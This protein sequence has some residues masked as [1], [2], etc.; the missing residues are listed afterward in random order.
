MA[1]FVVENSNDS[2]SDI[3]GSLT[4]RQALLHADAT[5]ETDT[6][7]FS[8]SFLASDDATVRL[9]SQVVLTTNVV[10]D[11]DLDDDGVADI[12]LLGTSN[13]QRLFT[14]SSGTTT[15]DTVNLERGNADLGGAIL[16]E[17]GA[18]LNLN[19]STVSQGRADKGGA[20]Y[21][22]GKLFVDESTF[23]SN[24]ATDSGGAIHNALFGEVTLTG[25]TIRTNF[26][27]DDD[28]GGG[29][30]IFNAGGATLN[31]YSSTLHNNTG[32][33]GG[34]LTN[35]GNATLTNA[36]FSSNSAELGGGILNRGSLSL[37]N[38]TISGNSAQGQG[39]GGIRN[40]LSLSLVN[41]IVI[42][43][44]VTD[45]VTSASGS[46]T[47]NSEL[48]SSTTADSIFAA[49]DSNGGG[50]L[51]DNGGPV[52][53]IALKF[54]ASNR[55]L[56]Q[57]DDDAAPTFDAA[58][59][60]RFD[61]GGVGIDNTR[62]DLGALELVGGQQLE[63]T[64]LDDVVDAFDGLVSLREALTTAKSIAGTD[65]ITFN[66]PG[67]L[68]LTSSLQIDD[69]V[70]ISGSVFEADRAITIT[71][72]PGTRVLTIDGGNV[73]LD[74]LTIEN[75]TN[76]RTGGISI[77][78]S[79]TVDINNSYFVG[80]RATEGGGAIQNLGILNVTNSTFAD[81]TGGRA[82]AI[83]NNGTLTVT[84]S[85]LNG[86]DAT[87]D[88]G[89]ILNYKT[90]EVANS[91]FEFNTTVGSGGAISNIGI[92]DVI[93]S[94]FR[95]NVAN[96]GGG[97]ANFASGST[98]TLRNS[99]FTENVANT[100]GGG[101]S[102]RFGASSNIITATFV[103]NTATTFGGGIYSGGGN[104][105]DPNFADSDDPGTSI[106]NVTHSTFLRNAAASSGG[107]IYNK[108][109]AFNL[110]N[111]IVLGNT[112]G[113]NVV[114][115]VALAQAL[116]GLGGQ[117]ASDVFATLDGVVGVLAD[118]GGAVQT[119]TL[120][121]DPLNPA[122]D[123]GN[124][125]AIGFPA[126]DARGQSRVDLG[127]V[128]NNGINI[129]DLGALELANGK[130]A[131]TSGAAVTVAEGTLQVIDMSAV[132]DFS[133]ELSG[134]AYALVDVA[135]AA[136]FSL[137][138][139]TGVLS[140]KSAPDFERPVDVAANNTYVVVVAV[141]DGTASSSQVLTITVTNINDAA[142]VF[143]SAASASIAEGT[144]FVLDAQATDDFA[145]EGDGLSYAISGTDAA[146]F[147][148]DAVTGVLS[149]RSAP[150]FEVPLNA[151]RNNIYNLAL[152]VS[153]SAQ[154]SSKAHTVTVTNVNE[155]PV[156]AIALTDQSYAEDTAVS[157]A[158]PATAFT[159]VDSSLTLSAT[160]AT[161]GALPS[162]L[163]FNAA[164]RAFSGTPPKDFNGTIAVNVT[165]SDGT[166]SVSDTFDLIITPVDDPLTLASTRAGGTLDGGAA[167]D[168]IA[169]NFGNDTL[170]GG[171]GDDVILD[172]GG[173]DVV[174]GG[175]GNDRIGL[176]SG[177]NTVSGG[178]GN[179]LIVG[180]FD[181]DK[182]SGDAGNDVI[183]GDVSTYIGGADR[184]TGGTGD[185]LLEGR[186]GAD[187]F[188]FATGDGNDTIGA[189]T[190]DL[191]NPAN[192]TM[193][194]PDFE[195]GIDTIMLDGFGF[196][197]GAAALAKVSDI[198]GVATFVD[199]GTSITFAGLTAA[200][201]ST[202]DFQFL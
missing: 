108:S 43:N 171:A 161:G 90:L 113:G 50:T 26:A 168:T 16:V 45:V 152:V 111:S 87:I 167:A 133:S 175:S 34:G 136:L 18:V 29:A 154:S 100:T 153:N 181:N 17:F 28:G 42:G 96:D 85:V 76:F 149:F 193:T 73:T 68:N 22:A 177:T 163:T 74:G 173:D 44:N 75:G 130:P 151:S 147:R 112:V 6:I 186:G 84:D 67:R 41:T 101:I 131:I 146:L 24:A 11:G 51:G 55:A 132:D 63:V 1:I 9:N 49:V 46:T 202:D 145:S 7:T 191:A 182:L 8:D 93:D 183:V 198:D 150:D 19:Q 14:V 127:G 13:T 114:G 98:L 200:D 31:V 128:Q 159:D 79:A 66:F 160:S 35:V 5:A 78:A 170:N 106:T 10:F 194:G 162:W 141:N 88:G 172:R 189:L 25:T 140:F 70:I 148:V 124:D 158:L 102:N 155:A 21:N 195:S 30:G 64:T 86:N 156:L 57:A 134:L 142:P 178:D 107:G 139:G 144:T 187:T 105:A 174:S 129:S 99:T 36:T 192:S 121:A 61:L 52:Q 3:P 188:I 60:Q 119:I 89:A 37:I 40:E 118:N 4:L 135:D 169:G 137:D 199:Q 104:F 92:T 122:L 197:D 120:K 126:T 180:G 97:I 184:I 81:N 47:T 125:S 190:L 91:I 165:A 23:H 117:T 164:T 109:G 62:A 123:A 32:Y 179:D 58:G 143:T 95:G 138:H 94:T 48:L 157:F 176:L 27:L 54:D 56:D 39:G 166:L 77:S 201:L 80:N 33:Y 72:R 103:E 53:T 82:G 71:A 2:I 65:T 20:I 69:D 38:N 15:F 83:L 196:A 185:D 115:N 12:T 116:T 59:N 110:I